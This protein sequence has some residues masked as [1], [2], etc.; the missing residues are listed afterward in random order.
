MAL[1]H[2]NSIVY[3]RDPLLA[4]PIRNQLAEHREDSRGCYQI[5]MRLKPEPGLKA[6]LAR[7]LG[8]HRDVRVDL[9]ERGSY[10]WAQIDGRRSLQAI[11]KDLRQRFA[12][13]P[14]ESRRATL[15]FTKALMVRHLILL[16]IED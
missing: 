12:L 6:Y 13:D 10:F 1:N 15:L 9:D 14:E 11:E 2:E 5:R 3:Q 4:I 8:F 7:T 16:K